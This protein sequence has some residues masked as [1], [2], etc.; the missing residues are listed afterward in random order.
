MTDFELVNFLKMNF[1][2]VSFPNISL[3]HEEN[4]TYRDHYVPMIESVMFWGYIML[5]LG[6]SRD[7][8]SVWSG[9][10]VSKE[11]LAI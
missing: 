10:L 7:T 11:I 9:Y 4:I 3:F 1:Q 5:I 2:T 6:W 8:E